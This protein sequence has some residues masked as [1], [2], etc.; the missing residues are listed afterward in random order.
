M[1]SLG[2]E[3]SGKYSS[4]CR[5]PPATK[6]LPS[7]ICAA[8]IDAQQVPHVITLPDV[9]PRNAHGITQKQVGLPGVTG[10]AA[11]NSARRP[12]RGGFDSS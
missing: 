3:P 9:H 10:H 1:A 5:K 8:C 11:P 12:L 4:C 7:Y 6:R 2:Q